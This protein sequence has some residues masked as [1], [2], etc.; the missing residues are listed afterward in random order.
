MNTLPY[1][2]ALGETIEHAWLKQNYDEAVFPELLLDILSQRTPDRQV[3][4]L[5]I[6]EWIFDEQQPF[7]QPDSHE[8]FGEPPVLLFEAPR[9][10]IEALFWLSGTTAIHEH[11]FSGAF[12]VLAGSSVHSHWRFIRERTINS[13]MLCGRLDRIST[14]ILHS[15]EIRSIHSGD[16]LIHQLF[17]LELPSVSI[18][19]R[20]YSDRHN[21]PQY[22]YLLPG[23]A[24]DSEDRDSRRVRRLML[25]EAMAKGQISGLRKCAM[26]LT[27]NCDLETTYAL[28]ST[29]A[30]IKVDGALM[31]ELYGVARQ[32]HGEI[33]ELFRR[34]C[35]EER[36]TR[37]VRVLRSKTSD[38]QARFLLAL[39]MLLPDRDS[40]FET[41]QLGFPGR[42]PWTAIDA[43]IEPMAGKD[44]IGF[45]YNATNRLIFRCLVEGVN[46]D[47][48]LQRLQAK[49]GS[50]FIAQNHDRLLAHTGKMAESPLFSPLYS[51]SPLR[52]LG[53]ETSVQ[54]QA[55]GSP[56]SVSNRGT[57]LAPSRD[58]SPTGLP[59]G[60]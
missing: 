40:I 21:L 1:F 17:H 3:E 4:M 28:F 56:L 37:I 27:N 6:I 14:E 43:C 57:I 7:R 2:H 25:L 13:R 50:D 15:G 29:L 46:T 31:E 42:D 35:D 52:D 48:L 39:L 44:T 18:V 16:R 22:K 10:Y 51:Q 36:R 47:T 30:R 38:P 12:M 49:F 53:A 20:T 59:K 23:L 41:I 5:D 45:D 8:F 11:S 54:Q 24:L 60:I 19:I 34:V 33:V 32:R 26:K 55:P 58:A 9:F